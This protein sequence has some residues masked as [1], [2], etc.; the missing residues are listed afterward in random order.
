M[1]TQPQATL[2]MEKSVDDDNNHDDNEFFFFN[3]KKKKK[4]TSTK[5][6]NTFKLPF[7][8]G[9]HGSSGG[10]DTRSFNLIL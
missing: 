10:K 1:A 9:H 7:Y 2:V 5:L 6:L 8:W 4:K 3:I